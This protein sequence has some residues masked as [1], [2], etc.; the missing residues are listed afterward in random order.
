MLS[1]A[2]GY[3]NDANKAGPL[4]GLD[5]SQKYD[6]SSSSV[7]IKEAINII[8][9][10]DALVSGGGAIA[11]AGC[12]GGNSGAPKSTCPPRDY[13]HVC[14][15]PA[16]YDGD[17]DI[18]GSGTSCDNYMVMMSAAT[19][20]PGGGAWPLNGLDFTKTF[21]CSSSSAEIQQYVKLMASTSA[22]CCGG[23]SGAPKSAC[24]TPPRKYILCF[25]T[26]YF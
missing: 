2:S 17:H 24:W 12:C 18:Q 4:H 1:V 5:F 21:D 22:G 6:C 23:N 19:G 15:V 11:G 10:K 26:D 13:S 7:A 25:F 14:K 16:N 8:A 9:N 3:Q 20:A